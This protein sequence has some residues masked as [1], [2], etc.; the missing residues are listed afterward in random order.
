MPPDIA[1]DSATSPPPGPPFA[2]PATPADRPQSYA[3]T[4]PLPRSSGYDLDC[5]TR[6]SPK[7][8]PPSSQTYPE[9]THRCPNQS[10]QAHRWD[11][12]QAKSSSQW[13]LARYYLSNH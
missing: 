4:A 11:I 1:A 13:S 10:R 2:P 3:T 9:W 6:A 12:Y 5:E 8:W 7:T